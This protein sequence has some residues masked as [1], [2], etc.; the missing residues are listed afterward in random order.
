MGKGANL[1]EFEEIVLLAVGRLDGNGHGASIH[2]EILAATN[3]DVSIAAV[4]VTLSRLEGKGYVRTGAELAGPRAGRP[5]A[6]DVRADPGGHPGAA[7][8]P[9]RPR[10]PLGGA[11]LRSAGHGGA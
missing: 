5:P 9:A 3:R 1:G 6:E 8:E 11:R 2:E 10:P 4:Y 7:G